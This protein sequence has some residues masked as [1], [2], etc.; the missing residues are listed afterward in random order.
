MRVLKLVEIWIYPVKSLGG[1]RIPS[2]KVLEK[3]LPFDR[4]WMLVDENGF[5]MTQRSYPG[6]ALIKASMDAENL[7][8]RHGQEAVQIPLTPFPSD[9]DALESVMVWN[10][11]V[12]VHEV[13]R[14]HSE[15]F[16]D[17]LKVKCRLMYFPEEQERA[18][19]PN[20]KVN[21]EQVSLADAFPFLIIGQSTLDDLNSKL[22]VPIP[23]NRFRPNF[24]FT[25]GEPFEEDTWRNFSIGLNRF[26]AVK[27][28]ARCPIPTIDQDTGKKSAEPLK[29]LATY[30]SSNNKVYFGQNLVALDHGEIKTGDMITL[31]ANA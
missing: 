22:A 10:D 1:I 23:M 26:V 28:C 15:W 13:S 2:S 8:L 11:T 3:G 4:R 31:H 12:T 7:V 20:Y 18:V 6:M 19:D 14:R 29:T 9:S 21:D 5:F 25:G 27:P 16:S 24:V 17:Q 30:R